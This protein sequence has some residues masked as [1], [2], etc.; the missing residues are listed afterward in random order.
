M[1]LNF[2]KC[3][4]TFRKGNPLLGSFN[5][6]MRRYLEAGILERLWADV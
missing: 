6:L 3:N 4:N 1:K 2:R 5:I